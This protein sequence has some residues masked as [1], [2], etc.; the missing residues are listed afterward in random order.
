MKKH[1]ENQLH[2]IPDILKKLSLLLVVMLVGISTAY[3]QAW[4]ASGTR[5]RLNIECEGIVVVKDFNTGQTV[6]TI[7][8][9]TNPGD[10]A[11]E[12]VG[13]HGG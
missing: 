12:H 4:P 13:Q 2:G 11:D 1:Y 5:L 3:S 6:T 9:P 7:A 8:G 10:F